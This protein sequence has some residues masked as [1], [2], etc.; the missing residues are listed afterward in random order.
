MGFLKKR[1]AEELLAMGDNKLRKLASDFEKVRTDFGT[2]MSDINEFATALAALRKGN[3]KLQP[4]V[5]K[6]ADDLIVR[7]EK[8]RDLLGVTEKDVNEEVKNR[9]GPKVRVMAIGSKL[10]GEHLEFVITDKK[11]TITCE[12]QQSNEMTSFVHH[13]PE[14]ILAS[15]DFSNRIHLKKDHVTLEWNGT[16]Y[17]VTKVNPR[18]KTFIYLGNGSLIQLTLKQNQVI[19]YDDNALILGDNFGDD[20]KLILRFNKV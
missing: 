7:I 8:L 6:R 2:I 17:V 16:H 19:G 18:G 3:N 14:T 4:L 11:I 1:S 9:D 10:R 20:D 12:K 5:Q 15:Y 13:L